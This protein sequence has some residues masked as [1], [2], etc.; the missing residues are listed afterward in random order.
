[1]SV[2]L[3]APIMFKGNWSMELHI[4]KVEVVENRIMGFSGLGYIYNKRLH[5]KNINCFI[6]C[7]SNQLKCPLIGG[8]YEL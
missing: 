3:Q 1:M 6:I 7:K 8:Y 5:H 2:P 4:H